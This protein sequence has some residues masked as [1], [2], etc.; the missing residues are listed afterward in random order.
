MAGARTGKLIHVQWPLYT[1][2]GRTSS[3]FRPRILQRRHWRTTA[4]R[5]GPT[6]SDAH[7]AALARH[8]ADLVQLPPCQGHERHVILGLLI[9]R[10]EARRAA[11]R[12][13]LAPE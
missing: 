6:Q 8:A 4:A 2:T 3:C 11:A 7:I 9:R 1:M 12:G 5:P 10:L 13:D